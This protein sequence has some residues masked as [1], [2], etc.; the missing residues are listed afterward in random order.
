MMLALTPNTE[1]RTPSLF[2]SLHQIL[3]QFLQGFAARVERIELRERTEHQRIRL[4]QRL[5]NSK[6]R[7]IGRLL[8]SGIF[9]SSL[10]QLF[11]RLRHVQNIVNDLERQPDLLSKRPQL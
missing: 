6:Q 10:A 3:C 5:V 4:L 7:G 9:S 8:G 1:S 11:R 2:L